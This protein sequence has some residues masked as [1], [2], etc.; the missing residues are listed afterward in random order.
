MLRNVTTFCREQ[1][2]ERHNNELTHGPRAQ[3]RT[4]QLRTHTTTVPS[5]FALKGNMDEKC[6]KPVWIHDRRVSR[7]RRC[8]GADC[9]LLGKHV[10]FILQASVTHRY[11][12]ALSM[13][14]RSSQRR[15][16]AASPKEW[17]AQDHD[18]RQN[19]TQKHSLRGTLQ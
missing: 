19:K 5:R 17:C 1:V 7:K 4:L 11:G 18:I 3:T 14:P 9:S 6:R 8:Q 15:L 2:S 10:Q 13:L 12:T 16:L